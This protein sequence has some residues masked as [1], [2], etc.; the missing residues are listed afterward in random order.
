MCRKCSAIINFPFLITKK[1]CH[2]DMWVHVSIE[3]RQKLVYNKCLRSLLFIYFRVRIFPSSVQ[4]I[5]LSVFLLLK[6]I[7]RHHLKVQRQLYNIITELWPTQYITYR[8]HMDIHL[9]N[10]V[11]FLNINYHRAKVQIHEACKEC[12][13]ILVQG[14]NSR[15]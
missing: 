9:C 1:R 15:K 6:C 4:D 10:I 2:W 7:Q 14:E 8:L 12:K 13:L 3:I 11:I 5:S